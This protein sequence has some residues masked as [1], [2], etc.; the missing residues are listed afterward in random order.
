MPARTQSC[1]GEI[2]DSR[3]NRKIRVPS[4]YQEEANL[5][6]SLGS[7]RVWPRRK[8]SYS[9]QSKGLRNSKIGWRSCGEMR[10][11]TVNPTPILPK[12]K[13][14]IRKVNSGRR[15]KLLGRNNSQQLTT[16][17]QPHRPNCFF[18]EASFFSP[19]TLSGFGVSLSAVWASDSLSATAFRRNSSSRSSSSVTLCSACCSSVSFSAKRVPIPTS[20]EGLLLLYDGSGLELSCFVLSL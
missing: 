8:L 15:M 12:V 3:Q 14:R 6:N 18:Q 9:K 19:S 2:R 10:S 11:P 20:S 4:R 1:F 7:E 17:L 5:Q 13:P 16:K